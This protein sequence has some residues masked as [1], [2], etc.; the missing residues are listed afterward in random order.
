MAHVDPEPAQVSASEASKAAAAAA[1]GTQ[2]DDAVMQ[3]AEALRTAERAHR[4][5]RAELRLGDVEPAEDWSTWYAEYLLG[6]R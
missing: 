1:E 2:R 5:Y 3:L 4:A 6:L